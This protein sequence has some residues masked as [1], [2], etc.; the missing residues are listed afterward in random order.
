[1][2]NTNG[3]DDAS[4]PSTQ[5]EQENAV[6]SEGSL[7]ENS[8]ESEEES[9][10]SMPITEIQLRQ[11]QDR[12]LCRPPQRAAAEGEEPRRGKTARSLGCLFGLPLLLI[13][14]IFGFPCRVVTQRLTPSMTL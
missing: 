12:R 10:A 3:N 14:I 4:I 11:D 13:L 9:V 7:A 5:Q 8:I 2:M 1:M 6:E